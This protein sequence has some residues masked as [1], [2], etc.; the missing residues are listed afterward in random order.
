QFCEELLELVAPVAVNVTSRSQWMPKGYG[1][2][3]EAR[4]ETF[5]PSAL[6]DRNVWPTLRAWWLA[7]DRGANTPNWDI[8]FSGDVEGRI[9]LVLVE[10]KANV[11]ELSRAGKT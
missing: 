5:G 6:P 3:E 10:A 4:L 8:A 9:G 7:H 11:P 1:H 2:S